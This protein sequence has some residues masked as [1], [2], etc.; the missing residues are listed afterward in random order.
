MTATHIAAALVAILA[1][2]CNLVVVIA[3]VRTARDLRE[4]R[5]REEA[6]QRGHFWRESPG[7]LLERRD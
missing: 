2:G 4:M 7:V 3:L 5:R 6:R 1:I